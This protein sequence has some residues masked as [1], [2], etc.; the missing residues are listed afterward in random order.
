MQYKMGIGAIFKEAFKEWIRNRSNSM[1]ASI[2]YFEFFSLA[3]LTGMLIY[4]SFKI[5]GDQR[6]YSDVIPL[7]KQWFAPQFVEVIKI[8]LIQNKDIDP[9][10]LNALTILTALSLAWGAKEYFN[11][12][13]ITID[14]TWNKR[15]E[16]FGFIHSLKGTLEVIKIG[17]WALAIMI[18]FL[19]LRALLPHMYL[20]S[21]E[22]D[23]IIIKLIQLF[24]QFLFILTLFTFLFSYAPPV[25]VIW[26]NAVPGAVLGA[27]FIIG[28]REFIH[29]HF[30]ESTNAGIA[31]SF[32]VVMIWFFYSNMIFTF[33]A[34]FNKVYIACR[35][36]IDLNSLTYNT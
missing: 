35:Q 11:Q 22:E 12:L 10:T 29:F 18:F 1:A 15:R 3:P 36:N 14:V 17:A 30:A 2:A 20:Q 34:E 25:K 8:M 6:T 27:I 19:F 24:I 26:K 31:E 4:L 7:L 9:N 28:G 23:P 5:L 13:K 16:T 33:A 32:L 21:S